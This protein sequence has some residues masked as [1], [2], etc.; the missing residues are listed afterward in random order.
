MKILWLTIDRT[1]RVAFNLYTPIQH[2]LG[3]Y[4]DMDIQT[5]NLGPIPMQY[6]SHIINN[7]NSY[8]K[9][10]DIK[11]VNNNY[12]MIITD[13]F[14]AYHLEEWEKIII[15]KVGLIE[16]QHMTAATLNAPMFDSA[17]FDYF[18]VRYKYPFLS[19]YPQMKDRFLWF[20]H[21]VNTEYFY[22]YG[23]ERKFG[24]QGVG[25]ILADKVYP[26]R[27]KMH[28]ELDGQEF[29]RRVPRPREGEENQWPIGKDYG[30]VLNQSLIT[31]TCSSRFRYVVSKFIE[32]PGCRS[33][34]CSDFVPEMTELGFQPDENMLVCP[35][36]NILNFVS[37]HLEDK[38]NLERIASNGYDLIK[39]RHTT[40]VRTKELYDWL[41]E[42]V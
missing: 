7:P 22:D 20:P 32:I 18:L 3:K 24:C 42:I 37:H 2:E 35:D 41:Q 15:P 9:E 5:K 14:F 1:K 6:I 17:K 27:Y 4:V 13:A 8:I 12:D 30:R 23:E 25:K 19:R 39:S 33:V 38:N 34:L 10:L 31:I 16:D 36:R 28:C 40:Q 29:Y 21:S 26:F 11:D